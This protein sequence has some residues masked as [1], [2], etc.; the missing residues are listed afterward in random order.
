RPAQGEATVKGGKFYLKMADQEVL[1]DGKV[2]AT[3][4][5]ESNEVTL[6]DY[7]EDEIG[8]LSPTRIYRAYK[9]GYKYAFMGETQV[10]GRTYVNVRLTPTASNSPISKLQLQ[11]DKAD[12]TI[13]GWNML[14]KGNESTQ[15]AVTQF[16]SNIAVNDNLLTYGAT[17][18]PGVEL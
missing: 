12:K 9:Q 8:D 1:S 13:R 10:N 14:Y 4:L 17:R 6:Q 16:Q 7:N 3:Y 15:F 2:L 5:K 11:I 18:F